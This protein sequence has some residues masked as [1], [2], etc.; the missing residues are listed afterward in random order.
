MK[1]CSFALMAFLLTIQTFAQKNEIVFRIKEK[2]L[3]PEGIAYDPS[4]N[5]FFVSSIAKRKVVKVGANKTASDF[6]KPGQD[7]L[8]EVLGMKVFNGSLWVCSNLDEAE[9]DNSMVHQ[10][11]IAS[12][13]L[14]RK[15]T[16]QTKSEK[17]LF[18]DL[19]VI[20]DKEAI[21]T[22]SDTGN[23]YHVSDRSDTP[24]LFL[25]DPQLKYING[26]TITP[27]KNSLVVNALSGFLKINIA[28][29]EVI[30]IPFKGYYSIGIDGLYWYNESLI[31]IQ[32]VSFPATIN[33]YFFDKPAAHISSGAVLVS[34]HP[35]WD[36][37]TT[38]V[39]VGDWFYYIAN[40][41]LL[42][43]EKGQV[44]DASQ[45]KDVLIMRVSLK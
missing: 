27:D 25:K 17:H 15:W 30:G 9:L 5:T 19:V 41:Q 31:G 10:F 32:N 26:I 24:E 21:V 8:G 14:I 7:G 6:M 40:S 18:N 22:D 44:K 1:G 11:D 43:Y 16:L 35:D 36:I 29:K 13:K 34:N 38:G 42:N 12:G 23:L 20:N 45:L 28:S 33:Q 37:P 39:I 3:I 2:D 4:S